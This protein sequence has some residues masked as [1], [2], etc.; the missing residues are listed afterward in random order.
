MTTAAASWR[1]NGTWNML[2]T[3]RPGLLPTRSWSRPSWAQAADSKPARARIGRASADRDRELPSMTPVRVTGTSLSSRQGP[4]PD[5][6]SPSA[7]G[8]A[9]DGPGGGGGPTTGGADGRGGQ[10]AAAGQ[11]AQLVAPPAGPSGQC[12]HGGRA[13]GG[14][15]VPDERRRRRASSGD[16]AASGAEL[17]RRHCGSR[18]Q[19]KFDGHQEA[20]EM[21]AALF[22][23][24]DNVGEG[25][26][27]R[28]CRG[29][30]GAGGLTGTQRARSAD[31]VISRGAAPRD[32]QP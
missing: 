16:A 14:G 15:R 24:R 6:P 7:A 27:S 32:S 11:P 29:R 31:A 13:G 28:A 25:D 21:L 2:E 9:L 26:L 8:G 19:Q 18:S 1:C 3:A 10:P 23:S 5:H 20:V 30:S 4:C 17:A 12:F 22:V